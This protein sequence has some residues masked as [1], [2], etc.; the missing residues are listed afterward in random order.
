MPCQVPGEGSVQYFEEQPVV[1][2]SIVL[3]RSI[4]IEQRGEGGGEGVG[5]KTGRPSQPQPNYPAL[6]L[7]CTTLPFLHYPS[8]LSLPS[9][10]SSHQIPPLP[11]GPIP[12]PPQVVKYSN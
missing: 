8:L 11:S 10:H 4:G 6:V 9:Y 7:Y 12:S 1:L 2:L 5:G 3:V